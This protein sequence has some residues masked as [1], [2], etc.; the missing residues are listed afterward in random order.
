MKYLKILA[1]AAIAAAA[2]M[3]FAGTAS[4]TDIT[5]TTAGAT[6]TIESGELEI[7]AE[8]EAG[9]NATLKSSF[10]GEVVCSASTMAG[11][12]TNLGGATETIKG[13][14]GTL[15]FT[16]CNGTVTVLKN[17]TLEVHTQEASANGNGTLT[18]SGAEVTVELAG[19]HCIFS[20][21]NTDVGVVKGAHEG[22]ATFE[23]KSAAIPRTGGRSGAFCG[24]SATWNANYTITALH[25]YMVGGEK[26]TFT[27]FTID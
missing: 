16:S 3:A 9:Q 5:V 1:V 6:D 23:A 2:L 7:T 17:G 21:S 12:T 13:N 14:I 26:T 19:L 18:S 15:T 11:K 25:W 20:T 24:S 4:A 27:N 22:H 10:I 8:L